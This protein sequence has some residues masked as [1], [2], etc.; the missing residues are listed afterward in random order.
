MTMETEVND[1]FLKLVSHIAERVL[2]EVL[3][4]GENE[5]N[6]VL[7]NDKVI[8]RLNRD[9]RKVDNPTDVLSF[10]YDEDDLLGEVIISLDTVKR[11]AKDYGH[12]YEYEL[13]FNLIH[14]ILHLCG[15]DHEEPEE[16]KEMM[17]LQEKLI[18]KYF[19][20]EGTR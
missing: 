19:Q 6:V 1:E 17:Q 15:Y 20:E 16:E 13:I 10:G 7:T 18:E 9:F 8:H 3:P 2:Q 11:Q 12:S 14:G 4:E 5:I